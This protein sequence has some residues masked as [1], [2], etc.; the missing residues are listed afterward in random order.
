MTGYTKLFGSILRSTVW[1]TPPHVRLVWIT[2][3]A[4]ADR[5][6][7][8]DSS[9][10]GLADAAGVE[11]AQCEHALALFL[12]PDPDS[13]TPDHEG[14]RI[15]KVDGGWRLLNHA[16]Y[17]EKMSLEDRRA[18]D[19]E[20]QRRKRERDASRAA[21]RDVT[22]VTPASAGSR[23]SRHADQTQTQTQ[24]RQDPA[25]T[26]SLDQV[27]R[28]HE[29]PGTWTAS[30]S[31]VVRLFGQAWEAKNR[32]AWM[33]VGKHRDRLDSIA[34]Q[35]HERADGAVWLAASIRGF[36]ATVDDDFVKRNR[37]S[38][39]VW[40]ADPGRWVPTRTEP[41]ARAAMARLPMSSGEQ[42]PEDE[43]RKT[44][45]GGT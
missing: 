34:A 32:D 35:V 19:A 3:L 44:F 29:V 9:V 13:R 16:K 14:R 20:R 40:S 25:H 18:K 11:R 33:G 36:F 24:T 22:S 4:L 42:L 39:A 28:A 17:A 37:W 30:A 5:D 27:A 2:M 23:E 43:I 15:E 38:F 10:P 31:L 12:A 45:T 1:R 41:D 26:R 7:V 6:G 21:S 8:V